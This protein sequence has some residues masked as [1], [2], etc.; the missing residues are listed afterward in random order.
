MQRVRN[1]FI[2]Q[3]HRQ[4]ILWNP[5]ISQPLLEKETEDPNLNTVDIVVIL[6][7]PVAK[8]VSKL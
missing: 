4:S 1:M 2:N 5:E 6:K 7:E 3:H 8:L